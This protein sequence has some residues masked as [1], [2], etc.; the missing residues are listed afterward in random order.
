MVYLVVLLVLAALIY[1]GWRML[2]ASAKRPPD[3]VVG[4]DDDPDFLW[5]LGRDPGGNPKDRPQA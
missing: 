2:R 4:P 5:R 3:R 1:L